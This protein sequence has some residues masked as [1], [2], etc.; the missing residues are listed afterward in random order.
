MANSTFRSILDIKSAEGL[1]VLK[2]SHFDGREITLGEFTHMLK[3]RDAFWQYEGEPRPEQPHALTRDGMCTDGFVDTLRLLCLSNICEILGGQMLAQVRKETKL[4]PF[5]W[6]IS[7]ANAGIDLGHEVGRQA[8]TNIAFTE[9]D[10]EGNP[11]VWKRFTV[12]EGET[13]LIVNE[14]MTTAHGSTYMAKA[15][16]RDQ[17]KV[18][19]VRFMPVVAVLVNRS[20][21]TETLE[22]GTPVAARFRYHMHTYQPGPATC[23]YCAAGSPSIKPKVE[24]NWEKHFASA[25]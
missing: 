25:I 2:P 10:K 23:K 6:T 12:A 17:N 16:V 18:Q 8:R 9:K 11:T 19:P 20:A 15:A 7:A 21:D 22:D 13:V 1:W 14:L 5:Q 4:E 3:L 24:G